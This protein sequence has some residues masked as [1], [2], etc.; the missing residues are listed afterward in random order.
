M[1]KA[2]YRM[3][4]C[5]LRI[6]INLIL[7]KQSLEHLAVV[8]G[9]DYRKRNKPI[10]FCYKLQF[11]IVGCGFHQIFNLLQLICVVSVFVFF[12]VLAD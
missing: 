6:S 3:V 5:F 1:K 11:G 12:V 7:C 9:I 4:V 8:Q 2:D 10:P